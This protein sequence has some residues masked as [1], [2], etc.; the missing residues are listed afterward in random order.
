MDPHDYIQLRGDIKAGKRD[1]ETTRK[2]IADRLDAKLGKHTFNHSISQKED[3]VDS[4]V[5]Q[6]Y[7][8]E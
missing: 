7:Y 4:C 5:I 3:V 2:D 6:Q 8:G 1:F